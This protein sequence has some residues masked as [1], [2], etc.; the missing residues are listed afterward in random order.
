[1][2][3]QT[4]IR[5]LIR[6]MLNELDRFSKEKG[7]DYSL[8]DAGI[9]LRELS[10]MK[11]EGGVPKYYFNMSDDFKLSIGK[12]NETVT[13]TSMAKKNPKA[14]YNTTPMGYYGY[15]LD[16]KHLDLFVEKKLPYL[17]TSDW[18]TIVEAKPGALMNLRKD[19]AAIAYNSIKKELGLYTTNIPGHKK[20]PSKN[21][22]KRV[23]N[24]PILLTKELIKKGFEWVYDPGRRLI[25]KTEPCQVV[26]LTPHSY[27]VVTK[28]PAKLAF[29]SLTDNSQAYYAE[30]VGGVSIGSI[31]SVAVERQRGLDRKAASTED[32]RVISQLLKHP[33]RQVRNAVGRK[34]DEIL[35]SF[36]SP[37][38][39]QS[40]NTSSEDVKQA[41]N[42]LEAYSAGTKT[43][44]GVYFEAAFY[45]LVHPSL[46]N[47]TR[48][49]AI[50]LARREGG[51][52]EKSL[53][54][55]IAGCRHTP[56]DVLES[57]I[58]DPEVAIAAVSNQRIPYDILERIFA[59]NDPRINNAIIVNDW[60]PV[61]AGSEVLKKAKAARRKEAKAQKSPKS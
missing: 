11:L 34:K 24:A 7:R 23:S 42:A 54:G 58:D 50:E 55:Y 44:P 29:E 56:R 22:V 20:E 10:K 37:L 39:S 60:N 19:S 43:R 52:V 48:R 2:R 49:R 38:S 18:L 61:V 30:P 16:K 1:M 47:D 57:I 3:K 4:M 5:T 17:Q 46:D 8:E 25:Y 6:E 26:F 33:H 31:S 36:I 14:E 53:L 21:A 13:T 28:I 59:L 41:F 15:P 32:P 12:G 40:T 35:A 51:T 9:D 45:I 27:D